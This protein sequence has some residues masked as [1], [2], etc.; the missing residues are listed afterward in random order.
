MHGKWFLILVEGERKVE[1]RELSRTELRDTSRRRFAPHLHLSQKLIFVNKTGY[2]VSWKWLQIEKEFWK[3]LK[4][5]P[6]DWKY[7]I[8][9]DISFRF[10]KIW[11]ETRRRWELISKSEKKRLVPSPLDFFNIFPLEEIRKEYRRAFQTESLTLKWWEPWSE[12]WEK[13]AKEER[14]ERKGVKMEGS[15]FKK[16]QP[17]L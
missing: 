11:C 8:F 12:S 13:R 3:V 9:S 14:E 17:P 6:Y 10:Q 5:E 7:R 15:L 4:V 2:H 16:Y 1:R